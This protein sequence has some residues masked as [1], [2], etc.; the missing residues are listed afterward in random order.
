MF[1]VIVNKSFELGYTNPTLKTPYIPKMPKTKVML[2]NGLYPK[3]PYIPKKPL[4][5]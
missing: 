2:E 3:N 5:P 4:Y 1:T